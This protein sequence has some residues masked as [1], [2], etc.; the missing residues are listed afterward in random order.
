MHKLKVNMCTVQGFLNNFSQMHRVL[1]N[2][3]IN[4]KIEIWPSRKE[5]IHVVILSIQ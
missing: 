2:M 1:Y 3:T 4:K 5:N